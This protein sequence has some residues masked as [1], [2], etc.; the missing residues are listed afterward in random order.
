MRGKKGTRKWHRKSREGQIRE[1]RGYACVYIYIYI[2]I[3]KTSRCHLLCRKFL[4]KKIDDT[5]L[6]ELG[7]FRRET[8]RSLRRR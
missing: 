7:T 4:P 1:E 3:Y 6:A 5:R 8:V 2:Y